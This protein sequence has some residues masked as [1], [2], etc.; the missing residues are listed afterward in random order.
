MPTTRNALGV[1]VEARPHDTTSAPSVRQL[2]LTDGASGEE[3]VTSLTPSGPGGP[4]RAMV[5]TSS[6]AHI[7]TYLAF[8]RNA[9]RMAR[10]PELLTKS[11]Q[12]LLFR[13]RE[14]EPA[15]SGLVVNA[16]R[17]A[18]LSDAQRHAL[19]VFRIHQCLLW[20]W[21]DPALALTWRITSDPAL[22]VSPRDTYHVL[23]GT[24]DGM[25]LAYITLEPAPDGRVDTSFLPPDED[26]AL[27]SAGLAGDGATVTQGK[28]RA[29]LRFPWL[30]AW[31][32]VD[33][34][35]PLFL[36]E[37]ELFGPNIFTS[38]PQL[39]RLPVAH[40]RELN[41]LLRNAVVSG[42]SRLGNIAVVESISAMVDL[43]LANRAHLRAILGHS[44]EEAYRLLADL[45]IP[46]LYAP[47]TP[48]AYPAIG[49]GGP[50]DGLWNTSM[51][52]PDRF[53]PFVIA[54]EDLH[55]HADYFA[56]IERSLQGT[57]RTIIRDLVALRRA[58]NTHTPHAFA[59][60]EAAPKV[61]FLHGG[62]SREP[63]IRWT[64]HVDW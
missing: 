2:N 38:L 47:H 6:A 26:R 39:A 57:Q 60:R 27:A 41:V 52:S 15:G 40:V 33:A 14:E 18:D 30:R 44:D 23:V 16:I 34:E 24:R 59:P 48:L 51:D 9:Q 63:V 61:N 45:D 37:R 29:G 3:P 22:D 5:E 50:K 42:S 36:T 11:A 49:H 32:L 12:S 21:Y 53:C 13:R 46:A 17:H 55:D 28:A 10:Y 35:R 7:K 1:A 20:E 64:Q 25:I 4:A 56:S 19:G 8:L 54:I 58:P 62:R 31:R 43:L